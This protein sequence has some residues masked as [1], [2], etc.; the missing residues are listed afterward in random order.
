[1]S[2]TVGNVVQLVGLL[3]GAGL[4]YWAAHAPY[5]RLVLVV[6]MLLAWIVVY[7]CC[8]SLGHYVV[9]RLLG[10]RFKGYGLRGTDH[11]ENY[12]PGMRQLMAVTPF[13][14][15]MTD[16][17]SMAKATPLAK[18]LMFAAGETATTVCSLAVALYAQRHDLPGAG[19]LLV[20]SIIFA[21]FATITTAMF[22]KGDYA[23]AIRALRTPAAHKV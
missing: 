3:V 14:T 12:P 19:V 8:H 4:I 20:F 17:D 21:V 5:R 22:P 2:V 16:K 6:L 13:F 15:V 9:G 18:A 11:P 7:I 10:I 1:M 23:K